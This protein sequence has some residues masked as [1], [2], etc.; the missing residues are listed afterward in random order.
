M[1]V[2][3][4]VD[5]DFPAIARAYGARVGKL[6]WRQR[7]ELSTSQRR[8]TMQE[9]SLDIADTD[10]TQFLEVRN[11]RP[12]SVT[13]QPFG[14]AVDGGSNEIL[15]GVVTPLRLEALLPHVFGFD[16]EG[17]LPEGDF[18]GSVAAGGGVVLAAR[19]PLVF[20]DVSVGWGDATLLDRVT[21]SVQYELEYSAAGLQ[22]R[23]ID[24]TAIDANGA[25]LVHS[26]SEVVAPLRN[27]RLI[28]RARFLTE[29]DL[30]PL[31]G[32]PVL[33]DLPPFTSGVLRSTIEIENTG[34]TTFALA[35]EL[36][37]A[38][39]SVGPLP[40][41]EL[42]LEAE[43]VR[44]ERVRLELPVTIASEEYGRSDVKLE[45]SSSQTR[46]GTR[47]IDA[48]LSGT[49]LA[50][51]DVERLLD[52]LASQSADPTAEQ[53]EA[54]RGEAGG[55][56]ERRSA[57]A[58]LR[59]KRHETPAW[60]EQLRATANVA[61]DSVVLPAFTVEGLRGALNVTP[62]RASLTD[63]EASLLGA[64]LNADANVTFDAASPKPYT[65]DFHA[66]IDALDLGL[67]FRSV[68]PGEE[69]TTEGVFDFEATLASEGLNPIDLGLSSLGEIRLDGRDG[70]FRGL[71]GSAGT[72]STA[73]K[74]IGILTFS[75]EFRALGR[76]LDGLG[77]IRFEQATFLLDRAVLDRIEIR[78]L[79]VVS[80]QVSID[81]TGGLALAP[82]RPLLLSPLDV[83]AQIAARG[84][85]ATLLDG[86][87]LLE[88]DANAYGYREIGK[89]IEIGGTPAEP[90]ASAFWAL[91]D[92]G[93]SNAQGS[94]GFAMRM[95]N[96]RLEKSE[97]TGRDP[98][99]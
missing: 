97:P 36:R 60:T 57:L 84:D 54:A 66:A 79:S 28:D 9:L 74:A 30:A 8:Y 4:A 37:D 21:M 71:A 76:L 92:E 20:R 90:D 75:Q 69:P 73:T 25:R 44:G 19:D 47:T 81:A 34:E 29:A 65:L 94:Y 41:V 63:L 39:T 70:I 14:V 3:V 10:G 32:Q 15:H 33:A 22:A 56:A 49:R 53:D 42:R 88:A 7:G 67:L 46:D 18:F 86:M 12:F 95:L 50:L 55:R 24:L 5:G 72:G 62:E 85:V 99:D 58:K 51:P 2:A 13:A 91:L 68:A 38:A 59:A 98:R 45:G 31:T 1:T 82:K 35:A 93:A 16:L 27:G 52:L 64:R 96:R 78:D 80:P 26:A 83:S 89:R 87:E 23:S 61:I 17:T 40:D 43:S 11:L 48:R 77:E 6:R